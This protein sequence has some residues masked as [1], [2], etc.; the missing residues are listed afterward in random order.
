M[1]RMKNHL[2]SQQDEIAALVTSCPGF[3]IE[4]EHAVHTSIRC[5]SLREGREMAALLNDAGFT[6]SVVGRNRLVAHIR[7]P[8]L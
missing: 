1:S 4:S 7:Q 6:A 8:V 5:P 3:T 2:L